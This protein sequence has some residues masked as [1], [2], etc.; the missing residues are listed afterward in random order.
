MVVV[1]VV[2]CVLIFGFLLWCGLGGR[3]MDKMLSAV[4]RKKQSEVKDDSR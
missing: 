3:K 1:E 2:V 4:Y